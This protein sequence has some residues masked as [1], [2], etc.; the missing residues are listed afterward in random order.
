M[1]GYVHADELVRAPLRVEQEPVP[2]PLVLALLGWLLRSL[3]RLVRWSVRHPVMALVLGSSVATAHAATRL[4]WWVYPL[5]VAVVVAVLAVWRLRSPESFRRRVVARF[6]GTLFAGVLYRPGWHAACE[7]MTL[8]GSIAGRR[9]LPRLLRVR[10]SGPVDVVTARMLPGQTVEHW[11]A[12]GDGFAASFGAESCRIT[13]SAKR[14][15]GLVDLR[16]LRTDPFW[17]PVPPFEPSA[18]P[19]LSGLPV[20]MC[21]DGSRFRLPVLGNHVLL[22]GAT[23][24]GK[25]SAVQTLIDQIAPAVH[26]GLVEL[27]GFDMKGGIELAHARKL[28]ARFEYN[29]LEGVAD[30][31]EELVALM[32]ARLDRMRGDT[33]TITPSVAEPLIVVL[34]DELAAI[35][36]YVSDN[37]VRKRI[38]TSLGLLLSQGRAPGISVVG[39]VQDPR[40]ETVPMRDL[41]PYRIAL[42]AVEAQAVDLVL[43]RG[44][45]ERGAAADR[46]PYGMPGVAYVEL[47]GHP[48]PIRVR[49]PYVSDDRIRATAETYAPG[50]RVVIP[51]HDADTTEQ[52]DEGSEAA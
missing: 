30:R 41:F 18:T 29:D 6:R 11:I 16:F 20:A 21:E 46:I 36:A 40:K 33:R 5:P 34:V 35:T 42:R 47:D 13:T 27:W 23:G 15:R 9:Y 39:A 44:A 37:A 7:S 50:P 32:R 51:L 1:N 22:G 25:S 45:R 4:G 49:F 52:T 12:Q 19:D 26:S 28:F 43:S 8:S 24:S 48:E 14:R 2:L 10:T 31:L 17:A 38:A 3:G